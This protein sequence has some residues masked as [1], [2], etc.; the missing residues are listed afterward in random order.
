MSTKTTARP[1][2]S[3][4]GLGEKAQVIRR[5]QS[6]SPAPTQSLKL[7]ALNELHKA[8]PTQK[9]QKEKPL[10]LLSRKEPAFTL[11][12]L[13]AAVPAHCFK[14][15]LLTSF[16]YLGADLCE[17]TFAIVAILYLHTLTEAN[18]LL[19]WLCWAL[20]W[21]YQ[22][23][24]WTGLWVIAHECGHGA[25]TAY[26]WLNDVIGLVLHSALYVPYF[27]WKYSHAK[28]HH[29]TNHMSMDE[30]FVPPKVEMTEKEEDEKEKEKKKE[31][32]MGVI[33]WLTAYIGHPMV[34]LLI[35]WPLY[36]AINA[37]GPP[38]PRLTCH[39]DPTAHIF[40]PKNRHKI[41]ISDVALV[42]WTLALYK[43]AETFGLGLML[44]LYLPPLL[45]TNCFLVSIT[46]LQHNHVRIPHYDS[47]EWTWLR[48]ALCTVDRSLGWYLDYKT[49]HIVDTHVTHHIFSQL[50]FYNAQEATK[51]LS[52]RL[53]D[54]YFEEKK[55][56]FHFVYSFFKTNGECNE[57][58]GE[59]GILWFLRHEIKENSQ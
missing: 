13:K 49:H 38:K 22:G 53:G 9:Q 46:Y 45:I 25:F 51:H 54:Y 4:I 3:E 56:F 2:Q 18:P 6:G 14:H 20:Y 31:E 55:G 27:S 8:D 59:N 10:L 40:Q 17:A 57:V 58:Q 29:Y 21:A 47:H 24:T 41:V 32:K 37:S 34:M 11:G 35:G 50:P 44:S 39:F 16:M 28:H 26:E 19:N 33:G 48:G 42:L 36:L 15:S 12:Q 23:C 5:K 7:D 1:K 43:L 52:A 30:P